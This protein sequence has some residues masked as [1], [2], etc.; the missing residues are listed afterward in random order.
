MQLAKSFIYFTYLLSEAPAHHQQRSTTQQLLK[1]DK[2]S[3][4]SP[5]PP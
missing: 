3:V 2:F 1:F 4:R 5:L